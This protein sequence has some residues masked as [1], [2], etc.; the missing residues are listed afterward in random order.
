MNTGTAPT[1]TFPFENPSTTITLNGGT[2][3]WNSTT[4]YIAKYDVVDNNNSITNV[5]IRVTAAKD[6]VGNT[7]TQYDVA[8]KFTIDMSNPIVTSV[9]PAPAVIKDANAGA[10]N[11]SLTMVYN[12][13][14]NMAIKPAIAFPTGGENPAPTLSQNVVASTWLNNTTFQ[15]LFDVTDNGL[16]M[17]SIDVG[18]TGAQ[19]LSA[20]TQ[21]PY[22]A[23]D[24]FS[25]D[26]QNPIVNSLTTSTASIVDGNVSFDITVVYSE[27]MNTGVNPSIS[28]PVENPLSTLTFSSGTWI[29]ATTYKASYTVTDANQ[30]LPLIDIDVSGAKDLNGNTQTLYSVLNQFG[31]DMNNPTVNAIAVN[32]ATIKDANV[33]TSTFTITIDYNKSMNGAIKPSVTFPVENPTGTITLNGAASVW[34]TATRFIAKY[35]VTDN[36]AYL[37]NV[38]VQVSAAKDLSGNLQTVYN[39]A[40]RFNIDM[41]NPVLAGTEATALSYTENDAATPITAN[42]TITDA[43]DKIISAVVQITTNYQSAEDLLSFANTANITGI[44]DG[45]AGKM[46]LS[47]VTTRANYEIA[48]RSVKYNNS[49]N[50]PNTTPRTVSFTIADDVYGNSNTKTRNINVITVNDAPI[51]SSLPVTTCSEGNAYTYT[52]SASDIDNAAG[53]LIFTALTIPAWLTLVNNGDGTASLS[54]TVPGSVARTTNVSIQ[55]SDGSLTAIQSYVITSSLMIR[56]PGDYPKIQ[57]AINA[58]VT[59]D[60]ILVDP[61]TYVENINFNGKAIVVGSHFMITNDYN[62]KS[63]TIIDGNNAGSVVTFNSGETNATS[64]IGFT[65]QNG[66]G[67]Y[68]NLTANGLQMTVGNYGG[69]VYCSNSSPKLSQV[70]IKNNTVGISSHQGGSGGGMYIGENSSILLDS[71]RIEHNTAVEYRGGGVCVDNSN[72]IFNKVLIQY[73]QGGNYGGGIALWHSNPNFID[74]TIKSNSVLGPNGHGGGIF[75]IHSTPTI[76]TVVN[77]GNSATISGADSFSF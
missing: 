54:G 67:S 20:N 51:F 48:L 15:A 38:D 74:V 23:G 32:L 29:N 10:S 13:P 12:K 39:S 61:G 44:W 34:S 46:T 52:V 6:A 65:I 40:D 25:I 64:L 73:N 4:Q 77:T 28:F 58:A 53:T 37:L 71:V 42:T 60:S 2:S 8:D 70:I 18:V 56:V 31:I 49:S 35:N 22:N 27:N 45:V 33:G 59:G 66:S 62:Y 55:V 9:T 47:G 16:L 1:I 50:N 36:G 69:G 43:G 5:D 75:K 68:L 30:N 26:M 63:S 17:S 72:P 76:G 3:L 11:F 57:L 24:N 14:M 21:T 7:Q 41:S 19:D